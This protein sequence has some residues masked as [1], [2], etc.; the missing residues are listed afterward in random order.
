MKN[1]QIKLVY[2]FCLFLV[3]L[4]ASFDFACAEVKG[5]VGAPAVMS[6]QEENTD[7]HLPITK[8]KK[9]SSKSK[10]STGLSFSEKSS[11][12][13]TSSTDNALGTAGQLTGAGIGA[14]GVLKADTEEDEKGKQ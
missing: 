8:D 5:A 13:V 9:G 1:L 10:S 4:M 3:L 2:S 12:A 11:K 7:S 14:A 6:P